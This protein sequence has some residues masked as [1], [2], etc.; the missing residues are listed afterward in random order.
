MAGA[1]P[2]SGKGQEGK[3]AGRP[4]LEE[5]PPA[6]RWRPSL[7][8]APEAGRRRLNEETARVAERLRLEEEAADEGHLDSDA[9]PMEDEAEGIG[10]QECTQRPAED[11]QGM[12]GTFRGAGR[13]TQVGWVG[14]SRSG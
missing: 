14:R 2:T 5:L 1:A 11:T 6:A 8:E 13:A 12:G 9:A 4:L 3:E 10:I 7:P